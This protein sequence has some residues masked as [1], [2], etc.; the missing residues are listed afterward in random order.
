MTIAL[1]NTNTFVLTRRNKNNSKF[2][3]I[4]KDS[5]ESELKHI[6]NFKT[7]EVWLSTSIAEGLIDELTI[8]DKIKTGVMF[9]TYC[10]TDKTF[11]NVTIV[12]G[13]IKSIKNGTTE[14]NIVN[15]PLLNENN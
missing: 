1:I 10:S 11:T 13:N 9:Y 14:D 7:G 2:Y 3:I 5:F 4:P 8:I 15:L 12:D 6:S